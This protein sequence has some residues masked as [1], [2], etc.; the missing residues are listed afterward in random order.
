MADLDLKKTENTVLATFNVPF[1]SILDCSSYRI[2]KSF[3]KELPIPQYVVDEFE[4]NDNISNGKGNNSKG[5]KGD[6]GD[7]K[8]KPAAPAKNE[9]GGKGILN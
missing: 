3:T 6:K 7:K 5:V 4:G 2:E 1:D 9:Q 8:S